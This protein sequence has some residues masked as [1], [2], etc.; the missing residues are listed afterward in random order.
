[1]VRVTRRRVAPAVAA[2]AAVAGGCSNDDDAARSVAETASRERSPVATETTG[3]AA[4][5]GAAGALRFS[6]NGDATLP[7]FSVPEGG[8]VVRW[9]NRDA[10]FSLFDG[11]GTVVDSVEPRGEAYLGAGVHTIDVIASGGWQLEI[12]G[13]RPARDR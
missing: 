10:V 11:R 6:G 1:M 13:A 8:A 3:G 12:P 2:L 7:P 5:T 4:R 9:T